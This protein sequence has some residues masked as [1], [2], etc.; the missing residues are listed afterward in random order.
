MHRFLFLL[1]CAFWATPA[2][3]EDLD[4]S[5][6]R[7]GMH[8]CP[9]GY[10]VS[11]VHVDQ[12]LLLCDGNQIFAQRGIRGPFLGN[13]VIDE[14][15]H[16]FHQR[17]YT[18]GRTMHWCGPGRV[19]T[20]VHVL[21]NKFACSE[22]GGLASAALGPPVLDGAPGTPVTVRRVVAGNRTVEMHACPI[23]FV[24]V[25]AYFAENAFL[26]AERNYCV[27]DRTAMACAPGKTCLGTSPSSLVGICLPPG[28]PRPQ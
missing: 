26:C 7:N 3:S 21:G 16:T 8:S 28:S 27:T 24:L 1:L 10:A 11:G 18:N 25:G 17:P 20:G 19:V 23:G 12:N 9:P 4:A 14:P 6:Q 22:Y 15:G 2:H 13:E 5:T